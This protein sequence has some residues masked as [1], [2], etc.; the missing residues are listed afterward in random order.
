MLQRSLL[1]LLLISTALIHLCRCV[2][3][4]ELLL[5]MESA[6]SGGTYCPGE[7]AQLKCIFPEGKL[8]LAWYVND[9]K[10]PYVVDYIAEDL[11]GHS[12]TT[13]GNYTILSI[14][15]EKP[16]RG[17]YSCAVDIP[18]PGSDIRSNSVEIL[19][20]GSYACRHVIIAVS[21]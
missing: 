1:V 18:T 20:E 21:A 19:F 12:A 11:P 13:L 6:R 2:Q 17:N 7:R 4:P 8:A 14:I 15:K 5:Y 3:H 16:Y 10:R 9:S